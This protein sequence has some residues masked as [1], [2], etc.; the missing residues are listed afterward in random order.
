[1]SDRAAGLSKRLFFCLF[2]LISL[3]F[4]AAKLLAQ[5][6]STPKYDIFVG[7]QWIH[8]GANVPNPFSSAANTNVD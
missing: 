8:S 1:M 6:D 2:A 5:D 4:P 3:M 7:Y